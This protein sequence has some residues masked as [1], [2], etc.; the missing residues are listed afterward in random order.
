MQFP[1]PVYVG[2]DLAT[3]P[4]AEALTTHGFD[5]SK[6]TL[7]TCEGIL[8]YLPQVQLTAW[9]SEAGPAVRCKDKPA[10]RQGLLSEGAITARPHKLKRCK[11]YLGQLVEILWSSRPTW[12]NTRDERPEL[13]GLE[14]ACL[15]YYEVRTCSCY[16]RQHVGCISSESCLSAC[17]AAVQGAVDGLMR[18]ISALATPGSRICFDAL[19]R[20]HM[21]GRVRNRGFSCGVEVRVRSHACAV[22]LEWTT[23]PLNPGCSDPYAEMTCDGQPSY[24]QCCTACKV[25]APAISSMGSCAS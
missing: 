17:Q 8:C 21:D 24:R 7:F 15:E 16:V 9:P 5:P 18:Q 12:I 22:T 10:C 13:G 14:E 2:A 3:T 1:R 6:P 20:D 4:V 23:L 19:H 25:P 11:K